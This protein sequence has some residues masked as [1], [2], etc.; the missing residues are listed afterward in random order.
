MKLP[1]RTHHIITFFARHQAKSRQPLDLALS[2]YFRAHKSIGAHDRR[3][4]GETIYGLTRWQGLLDF[5]CPKNSPLLERLHRFDTLDWPKIQADS[6]IPEPTR[7]GTTP[8]LFEALKNAYGPQRARELCRTFLT[9]APTAIRANRLKI[10]REALLAKWAEKFSAAPSPHTPDGILFSKRE[11]L[12]ALPEF[13]EGLFEMQDEGSQLVASLI[14]AQKGDHILDYCSGSGGKSLAF[15]PAMQGKGQIYLHD[16]RKHALSQAK[17]RFNRAGIQHVQFL[18]PEHPN[19]PHLLKKM[20]WVLADVPCSGTGTL[21]RHPEMTWNI[22]EPLLQ[23][24]THQQ[25]NIFNN[26]LPYV[27]P[28]GFIVYATCS[29]LPQENQDQLAFFLSHYPLTLEAPPLSI[30]PEEGKM[31]GFF[32][33][34]FRVP[35]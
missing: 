32:A 28:G 34:V 1:F 33:A 23:R 30:L 4:I 25:K 20:D 15:A 6:S 17:Q 9:P 12:F 8:F 27:R 11:A 5:L 22:D 7:L 3:A 24:L 18:H 26:A 21:R 29:I 10:S 2:T 16:I 14:K 13:K 31:D 19:L 35:S